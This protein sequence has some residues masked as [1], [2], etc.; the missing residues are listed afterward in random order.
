[1]LEKELLSR[2]EALERRVAQLEQGAPLATA[3]P[4]A[5]DS[6]RPLP[7]TAAFDVAVVAKCILIV[8]G[9][10]LAAIGMIAVIGVAAVA[11]VSAARFLQASHD[12]GTSALTKKA[13]GITTGT[14]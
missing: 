6:L 7:T 4:V 13:L 10:L 1:M 14:D 8:G 5:S 11:A 2:L 9:A 3:T 12:P